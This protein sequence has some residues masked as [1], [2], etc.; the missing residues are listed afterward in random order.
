V[1]A[2]NVEHALNYLR[3][4]PA[5]ALVTAGERTDLQLTALETSTK[6][7]ILTG[8]QQ[9]D[10]LVLSRARATGVPVILSMEDTFGT[11]A[12]I[13]EVLGKIRMTRPEQ[14]A[15]AEELFREGVALERIDEVLGLG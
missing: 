15:R 13:E 11:V 12:R 5:K 7:I 9:P 10:H 3:R 1:G 14:L 4:T 8:Q 6:A 2:M